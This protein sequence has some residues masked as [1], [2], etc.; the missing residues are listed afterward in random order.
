MGVHAKDHECQIA[1]LGTTLAAFLAVPFGFLGARNLTRFKWQPYSVK[2]VPNAIRTFPEF[3]LGVVFIRGSGLRS[4]AGVLTIGVHSTGM[5]GKLYSEVVEG[6]DRAPIE[7]L[8]A[9]GDTSAQV[10]RYGVLPQVLPEFASQA[11]HRLEIN[12]RAA[13]VLGLVGAGGIGTPL[14]FSLLQQD[15]P[16][17]GLILAGISL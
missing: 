9:S 5:L 13:S 4:F 12:M 14:L 15:W 8:S 2:L 16:R 10:M 11:I 3:L 17:V 7:A 1:I 6:I